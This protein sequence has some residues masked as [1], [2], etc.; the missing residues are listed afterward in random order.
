MVLTKVL[1][2]VGAGWEG[3]V[4]RAVVEV[5][6]YWG[7]RRVEEGE[8]HSLVQ[9]L[10]EIVNLMTSFY[11]LNEQFTQNISSVMIYSA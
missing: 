10:Q 8:L 6:D 2:V 7:E 4:E 9:E 1:D 3:R 5:L 11:L